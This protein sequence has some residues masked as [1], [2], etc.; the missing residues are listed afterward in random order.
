MEKKRLTA[1]KA[2]I[3]QVTAGK[4]V[5]QPGF[6]SNYVLTSAGIRV[7]RVRLL[8]TVVDKFLSETGR[9]ATITL[10][11]GTDTIR[12][13]VFNAVSQFDTVQVGDT[14]DLVGKV[15]EYQ[16]ELYVLPEIIRK[17]DTLNMEILRELELRASE[18]TMKK[19][20]EIIEEY[21]RQTSDLTELQR[22]LKERFGIGPKEVESV[23]QSEV[24]EE[25]QSAEMVQTKDAVLQLIAQLDSGGGC[26]YAEL[27]EKAG[28]EEAM[29]DS[30][31]NELLE[32]GI[33]FEPRP[34]KI[35]KL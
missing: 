16:G 7:S 15:R 8:G 20:R 25:E 22:L 10:D 35:K 5:V 13:K 27:M 2:R 29:L 30:V 33:C 1:M 17:T 19:K 11:D 34:G 4:Y 3:S 9:F 21:S 23:M 28:L 6:E 32:D 12:A 31:V 18:Q 14:V 24:K 26:D